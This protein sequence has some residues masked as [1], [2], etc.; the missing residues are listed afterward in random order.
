MRQ[1]EREVKTDRQTDRDTHT[2]T[3]RERHKHTQRER[4]TETERQR[5]ERDRRTEWGRYTSSDTSHVLQPSRSQRSRTRMEEKGHNSMHQ[6][7]T[8]GDFGC[9][10][11]RPFV[12][13]VHSS[14]LKDADINICIRTAENYQLSS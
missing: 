9:R 14:S 5:T 11:L 6:N 8:L 1:K 10:E 13:G 7:T 2:Q 12:P 3:R 4:D